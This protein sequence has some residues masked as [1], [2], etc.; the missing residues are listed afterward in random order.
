LI[1]GMILRQAALA[2]LTLFTVSEAAL[3][4]FAG[5][6]VSVLQ[7]DLRCG[8][9]HHATP[10]WDATAAPQQGSCCGTPLHVRTHPPGKA[11]AASLGIVL[12]NLHHTRE[13]LSNTWLFS[14]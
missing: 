9:E 3:T 12:K 2:A 10:G 6:E 11:V 8:A 5:R 7:L 13:E 14:S 4:F 1:V